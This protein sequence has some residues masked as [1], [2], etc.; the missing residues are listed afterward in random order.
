[1]AGNLPL[2]SPRYP[3]PEH[4]RAAAAAVAF[5]AGRAESE[6]ALLCASCARG[7]A[8][9]DSDV[10]LAVL[11]RPEVAA[12]DRQALE[13]AWRAFAAREPV[14]AALAAVGKYAQVGLELFDGRFAPQG[15]G[16]TSGPDA[17]ELEIGNSL[18]YS[19]PLWER[20]GRSGYLAALRARWLP[21]YGDDLRATRLAEARKFCVNNLDHIP[22]YVARGLYFQSFDRL[23]KAFQEFLQALFITHRTYPIAYDKWV[24]EQVEEILGLPELYRQLPPLFEIRRF[25]SHELADKA[26]ALRAL[27]DQRAPA[28]R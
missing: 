27:L 22:L 6:A 23:W 10:D 11:V 2:L 19:V 7:K 1:M 18:A 28:G 25:E 8:S 14:F 15:R 4:E 5:F 26:A 16:W 17:F 24:R 9:P 3:T 21:Y 20:G 12:D 13:R